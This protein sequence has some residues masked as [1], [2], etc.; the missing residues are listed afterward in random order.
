[1]FR[2]LPL[3]A[4]QHAQ[5]PAGAL[6]ASQTPIWQ[7]LLDNLPGKTPGCFQVGWMTSLEIFGHG[8]PVKKSRQHSELADA[9]ASVMRQAIKE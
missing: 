7:D 4:R 8:R 9:L 6:R 1:M 2:E 3:L 5:P